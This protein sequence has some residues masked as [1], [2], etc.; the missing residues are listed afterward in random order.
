[1]H[2]YTF[3][4]MMCS[5]CVGLSYSVLW[6]TLVNFSVN[7]MHSKICEP[8]SHERSD[9]LFINVF[10]LFYIVYLILTRDTISYGYSKFVK[11]ITRKLESVTKTF[12][13]F[14][15]LLFM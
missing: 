11:T 12:I 6:Y 14:F 4:S 10:M 5:Y 15:L 2:M 7:I 3:L 9:V 8:E 13:P 1:M